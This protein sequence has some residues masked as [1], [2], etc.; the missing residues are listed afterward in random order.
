M[1]VQHNNDNIGHIIAQKIV[2]KLL[3]SL[4]YHVNL[5]YW[6]YRL[7]FYRVF[8]HNHN[9]TTWHL[10]AYTYQAID[11]HLLYCVAFVLYVLDSFPLKYKVILM[12]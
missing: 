5:P 9:H 3:M 12:F 4:A 1:I 10:Y 8:Y 7:G 6:V 11:L 2:L